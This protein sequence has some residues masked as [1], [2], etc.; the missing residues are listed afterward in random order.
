MIKKT[1]KITSDNGLHARPATL[2]VGAVSRLDC[3]VFIIHNHKKVDLK[4]IMGV[5]SMGIY[6]GD[7][8]VFEATG[9]EE[10]ECIE[11]ITQTMHSL[12]LGTEV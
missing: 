4:S 11:K 8:V 9:K 5:M 12:A 2:L 3:D 7:I 6:C 10:I 1:F